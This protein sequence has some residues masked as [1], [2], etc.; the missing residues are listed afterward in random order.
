MNNQLQMPDKVQIDE[1]ESQ[2]FGRFTIQPLEKGYGVTL[3]N[4]F[5]RVLL[6]SVPGTA[7]VGSPASS[8]ALCASPGR[9]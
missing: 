2:T 7:I 6:S 3:G 9:N 4:S 8:A 5:R 1:N